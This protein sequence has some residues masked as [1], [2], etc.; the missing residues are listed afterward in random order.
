MITVSTATIETCGENYAR[1]A[2]YEHNGRDCIIHVC[3]KPATT[4]RQD[5]G[6]RPCTV[7]THMFTIHFNIK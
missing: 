6:R 1:K 3:F 4:Q 7:R 5:P 2:R